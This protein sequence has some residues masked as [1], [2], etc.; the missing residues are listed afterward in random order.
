MHTKSK[1][2]TSKFQLLNTRY[3]LFNLKP[4]SVLIKKPIAMCYTYMSCVMQK[5]L[6]SIKTETE[7]FNF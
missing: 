7:L 2:L 6:K 3:F 5:K 1:S 4:I